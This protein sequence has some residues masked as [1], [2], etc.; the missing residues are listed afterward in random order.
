[1]TIKII[2]RGEGIDKWIEVWTDENPSV[3]QNINPFEGYNKGRVWL[4]NAHLEDIDS[5]KIYPPYSVEALAMKAMAFYNETLEH[6]EEN[7]SAAA[8]M[9]AQ[10]FGEAFMHM[11]DKSAWKK[12]I[13]AALK[14]K[15]TLDSHRQKGTKTNKDKAEVIKTYVKSMLKDLS[16]NSETG[17]WSQ[18]K[19]LL[20]LKEHLSKNYSEEYL[21]GLC[22]KQAPEEWKSFKA[23]NTR[24]KKPV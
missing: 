15:S 3:N 24:K 1:M 6:I 20:H 23:N 11:V 2:E 18:K 21:K 22:R 19:V 9:A 4:I 8:A 14:Q 16:S 13:E 7:D 5:S 17:K 10:D 12:D